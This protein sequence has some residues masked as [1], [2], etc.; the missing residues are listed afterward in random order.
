MTSTLSVY[1]TFKVTPRYWQHRRNC[2][3]TMGHW[4]YLL[5]CCGPQCRMWLSAVGHCLDSCSP[6][7]ST[8]HYQLWI[9]IRFGSYVYLLV[10]YPHAC[11]RVSTCMWP[12]IHV[13]VAV[14]SCARG[15][16][17]KCTWPCIQVHVAV[18]P[19]ARGRVSKCT[20]PCIQVYVAV[21]PSALGRVFTC[22][23]SCIHVVMYQRTIGLVST[24]RIWLCAKCMWPCI[25]MHVGVCPLCM[26][27]VSMCRIL[28]N[29]TS[30]SAGSHEILI[31]FKR[32]PHP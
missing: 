24:F 28:L 23:W 6:L 4:H 17:S 1:S 27:L 11:G 22:T 31:S 30:H 21:Y 10:I 9:G 32:L 8:A 13:R 29:A 25:L 14:Y 19:S 5:K 3:W 16:V 7:W 26:W 18:Y 12:C 15:R 2:F 20:W